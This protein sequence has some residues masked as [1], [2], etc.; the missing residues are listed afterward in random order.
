VYG[1]GPHRNAL[2]RDDRPPHYQTDSRFVNE[3]PDGSD[4]E[5]CVACW[6]LDRRFVATSVGRAAS[7]RAQPFRV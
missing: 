7:T 1:T 6:R 2:S 5:E 3:E 4:S